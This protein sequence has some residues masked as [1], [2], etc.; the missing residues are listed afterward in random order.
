MAPRKVTASRSQPHSVSAARSSQQLLHTAATAS[1]TPATR[2]R[3]QRCSA[4]LNVL[5]SNEDAIQYQE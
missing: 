1:V 5:M 2:F 4:S 3:S